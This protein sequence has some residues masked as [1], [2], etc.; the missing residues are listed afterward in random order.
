MAAHLKRLAV[1]AILACTALQGQAQAR[2]TVACTAPASC[3]AAPQ[4]FFYWVGRINM[5]STVMTV[6]QG[7]VPPA[8]AGK[9]A[10]A[11]AHSIAQAGHPGGKRPA[12]VLQI[13]KLI[14]DQAGPEGTLIHSGR[15]RQDMHATLRTAQLRSELL[16]FADALFAVRA[17]LLE[18]A[19]KHV[20]TLV[21]AYTNGVQA[22]P[23]SYAHYLLAFADSFARDS[24]RL[25]QAYARVNRSAMGTAVLANSSWPLDRDRLAALLGFDGL[26]VNSYD[27]GQI[28]SIDIP[29]EAAN[30]AGSSAIRVGAFLQDVHVQYHQ[31]QPWLL[32]APGTTYT[33]SAMPQK[34]NP[35]IIQSTRAAASDVVGAAQ[36]MTLR[37]HN[38]TPGMVDYK[39]S[40][41]NDGPQAL[42]RAAQLMQRFAAVLDALRVDPKRA[43]QELD[44]DWTTSMEVAETLQRAHD[45]PFRIGHH[46]ASELVL[47]A[48]AHGITPDRFAHRDAVRIYAQVAGKFALKDARLPLSERAFR[49]ALSAE[50]MVRTRVGIGGPQPAEVRRMLAMASNTLADDRRWAAQS[51]Q[52]IAQS[53][54]MLEQAFEAL[55]AR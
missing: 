34:A 18:T 8:L 10:R 1:A 40:L 5:A 11:V 55:L 46:F 48:R 26:V 22:M 16:D 20:D 51:R 15:S 17:R 30:V 33:S 50:N 44:A 2:R 36:L 43:R 24:E 12:D 31:V 35:G 47:H 13:E 39:S 14:T 53:D 28:S 52:R 42:G 41:D 19:A 32:L 37:A 21:P 9:V 4:D 27:A 23:T 3:P 25:R 7:I 29:I 38:V 54:A 45:I 49:Q 6:E